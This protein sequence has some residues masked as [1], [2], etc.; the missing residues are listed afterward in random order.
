[1]PNEDAVIAVERMQNYIADNLES[2]ITLAALA[3]E[4]GYSQF[5]ASRIFK[6]LT[7]KPPFEYIRA[8]RLTG[9]A[10]KLRDGSERIID[11]AFDFV[12][13]SH[14]GFTRS[15]TKE[16]G[17]SPVTYRKHPVPLQYFVPYGVLGRYLY[18]KRGERK[19]ETKKTKTVFVQAVD[20]PL[21]KAI[22]KRGVK[23][24]E[25][26]AYCEEVGC[27]IWGVLESIKEAMFE[28]AGFW[29]P[30]KLIKQGTSQYVQGVEVPVDYVGKVPEGYDIIDLEPCKYLVF[31][32]EPFADE[33]FEDAIA[34]VWDTVDKYS[35]ETFGYRKADD[36]APKFQLSP[37]GYRG[38]IEARPVES[39]K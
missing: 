22:I 2:E 31:Q 13:D 30:A 3:R 12:F 27:D 35:F 10:R 38:Y 32:G 6:E 8:M 16:F 17:L 34:E 4:G 29:L 14:E 21:R 23:A 39:V 18:K 19:M 9:A 37:M 11:V 24:D 33:D 25:Y 15:F 5:H 26:F 20:R 1:M 36:K 28:P 7:G